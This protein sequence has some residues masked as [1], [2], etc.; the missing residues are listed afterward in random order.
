MIG[1]MVESPLS[2]TL[3]A[4]LVRGLG[5]FDWVDL[6]TPLFMKEHPFNG[7]I[8]FDSGIVHLKSAPGLGISLNPDFEGWA[9]SDWVTVWQR[10]K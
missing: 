7:G 1:G 5:R 9:S 6:D 4:H 10:E 3:S 8:Q 2:M